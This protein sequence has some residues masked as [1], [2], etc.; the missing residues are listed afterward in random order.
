MVELVGSEA[1]ELQGHSG[2]GFVDSDETSWNP[3]GA[4]FLL[5][6]PTARQ[7]EIVEALENGD[8]TPALR[9]STDLFFC[10]LPSEHRLELSI[11]IDLGTSKSFPLLLDLLSWAK[12]LNFRFLI[13]QRL[14]EYPNTRKVWKDL[15]AGK[16]FDP[17]AIDVSQCLRKHAKPSNSH[18]SGDVQAPPKRRTSGTRVGLYVGV[19]VFAATGVIPIAGYENVLEWML[20]STLSDLTAPPPPAAAIIAV[21]Y[22][23]FFAFFGAGLGGIVEGLIAK[24][25]IAIEARH[26]QTGAISARE[27]EAAKFLRAKNEEQKV[28]IRR[29]IEKLDNRIAR[30]IEESLCASDS[31]RRYELQMQIDRMKEKRVRLANELAQKS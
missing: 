26:D 6:A 5:T 17:G 4:T 18:D 27:A 2:F 19:T 21:V 24:T 28:Q 31:A 22:F 12:A 23:L 9:S 10:L 14:E 13:A 25:G 1:S 3:R 7:Q 30:I 15:K 16:D 20:S 8:K 11:A 29:K